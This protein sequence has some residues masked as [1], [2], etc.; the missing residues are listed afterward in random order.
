M[1]I[2]YKNYWYILNR[3][4]Q[5]KLIE[6]LLDYRMTIDETKVNVRQLI[7]IWLYVILF[8]PAHLFALIMVLWDGGLKSFEFAPRLCSEWNYYNDD[9]PY[10]RAKEIWENQ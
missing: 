2:T 1:K 3:K 9:Y 8:I 4:K 7:P 6:K 5:P 10:L